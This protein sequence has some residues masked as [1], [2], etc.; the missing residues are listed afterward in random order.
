[1][2]LRP[3]TTLKKMPLNL[4]KLRRPLLYLIT[5]GQTTAQTTPATKD[6]ADV[7]TLVRAAVATAIDLVQIREKN[8]SASVLYQ[9]T[10]SA[11][12]ITR[13][14]ATKLLANDRSD[15]ALVA[16]A[17]G[18]HL[19][20]HSLPADVVRRTFGD[21]FLIGVSTHSLT[22]ATVARDKGADFVV[23]GPVF[24]TQSKAKGEYGE[25]VGL[26]NLA[27]VAGELSPFPVLA[28]GG[29]DLS[30]VADCI[31]AGAAGVAAIRMFGDP[32]RLGEIVKN[33][34]EIFSPTPERS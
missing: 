19:T 27:Q 29:L 10:A 12:A 5:S 17:D 25:P 26:R 8:L 7:L 18:V 28:L 15:I 16:G 24:E 14:T 20:T 4:Q 13:G 3:G 21:E 30:K 9:L 6:F 2:A 11:A 22:E 1:M 33:V 31:Q 32:E 34:H 23:F